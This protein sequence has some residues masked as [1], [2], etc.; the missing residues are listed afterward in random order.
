M[1]GHHAPLTGANYKQVESDQKLT[2][3]AG[4]LF[5]SLNS[6]IKGGR[7]VQAGQP[8]TFT[9]TYPDHTKALVWNAPDANVSN[10]SGNELTAVFA[11][12]GNYVVTLLV[13]GDNDKHK[14]VEHKVTVTEGTPCNADFVASLKEV[15]AGQRVSFNP[16]QPVAGYQYAWTMP[17][18]VVANSNA[19]C[20]ATAYDQPG[21]HEVTLTVTSPTGE[22]KT[23]N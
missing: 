5:T 8:I 22:K 17:G 7:T 19:I 20:A 18:G 1:G 4:S 13:K 15:A 12:P 6:G 21:Q 2:T 3:P 11:K 23:T 16:V 10:Y 9:A 14:L